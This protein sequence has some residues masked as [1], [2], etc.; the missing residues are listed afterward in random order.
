M[1]TTPVANNPPTVASDA[2]AKLFIGRPV[3]NPSSVARVSTDGTALALSVVSSTVSVY[4]VAVDSVRG[5]VYFTSHTGDRLG[6]A[7]LDGTGLEANFIPITT[8]AG[9]TGL[10][11]DLVNSHLYWAQAYAPNGGGIMRANLDGTGVTQVLS[12]F[13]V[14]DIAL[15][16]AGNKIYYAG[17]FSFSIGRCD[18]NGANNNR[19]WL[20]NVGGVSGVV[21]GMSGLAVDLTNGKLYWSRS[22]GIGQANLDGG[23]IVNPFI[24]LTNGSVDI[25]ADPV[26][27]KLFW[28]RG[29]GA[30]GC[31]NLNE[32]ERS[33]RHRVDRRM[34]H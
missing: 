34:G 24:T 17:D 6:R 29:G 18:L 15:N 22:N 9:A 23:S 26:N 32:R 30:V 12:G 19:T 5:K 10:A 2:G 27:G 28:T 31:A 1:F 3:G 25:V 7:N 21:N 20:A 16:V 14:Y 4:G 11:I 33:S 8:G 13:N